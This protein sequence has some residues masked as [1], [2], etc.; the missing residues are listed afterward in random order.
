MPKNSASNPRSYVTWRFC[1]ENKQSDGVLSRNIANTRPRD[2]YDLYILHKLRGS[3]CDQATLCRALERTTKKRGSTAILTDYPA[4]LKAI[5]ESNT[6][7][8]QW[9]KYTHEYDY[10]KGITFEE[11]CNTIEAIM[12]SIMN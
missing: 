1:C 8:K 6:L 12:V 4:I 10:A 2:Y 9:E 7:R 11:T 3:R 5:R